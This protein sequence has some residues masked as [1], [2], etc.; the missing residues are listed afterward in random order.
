MSEISIII[1]TK[2]EEKYLEKTLV[3]IK[4]QTYQPKKIIIADAGS[5]DNTRK[6]AKSFGVKVIRGGMPAF[7]RNQGAKKV[8]SKYVMFL[9]ADTLFPKT[10]TLEKMMQEMIRKTLDVGAPT[11][12][13][14]KREMHKHIP[15]KIF[16]ISMNLALKILQYTKKPGMMTGMILK[17]NV[18][19]TLEGFDESITFSEDADLAKRAKIRGYRFKIL[20]EKLETSVRRIEKE[21]LLRYTLKV[22]KLHKERFKNK[23]I[24]AKNSYFQ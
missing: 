19:D 6:I 5:K 1:P 8:K 17:K 23:E 14:E 3:S 18:F 11:Y 9:D 22:L 20:N 12:I 10:N 4:S 7:G 24:T 16:F 21:G 2:N 13:P 15:H